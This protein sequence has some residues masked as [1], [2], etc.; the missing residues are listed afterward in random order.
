MVWVDDQSDCRLSIVVDWVVASPSLAV[1]RGL[2]CRDDQRYTS[3]YSAYIALCIV[4][5]FS[6][7]L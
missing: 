3:P 4:N 7:T 1:S 5:M 2:S 6:S